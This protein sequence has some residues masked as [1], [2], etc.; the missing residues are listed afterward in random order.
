M[1]REEIA[2]QVRTALLGVAPE[3]ES[4]RLDPDAPLRDQVDIDSMDFLRFVMALHT[5]LGIDVPE[6]DYQKLASLTRIVDYL[7]AKIGAER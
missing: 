5:Q 4:T 3:L 7:A 6:A 1:T 2:R